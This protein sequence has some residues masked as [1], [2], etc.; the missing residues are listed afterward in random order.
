MQVVATIK[1]ILDTNQVSESFKLR[2][3]H[4]ETVEQY[5]QTL[6]IQFVQDKTPLLDNFKVGDKV[7]IEIN[8]RGK[9]VVKDGK[10]LVFNTIQGWKIEKAV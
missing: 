9:E 2:D 5:A 4:V 8:L 1:R 3:V 7:K 6:S 10:P